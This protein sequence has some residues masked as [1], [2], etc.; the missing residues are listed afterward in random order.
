MDLGVML[1]QERIDTMVSVGAWPNKTILDYVDAALAQDPDLPAIT[2]YNGE[3]G[4]STSISYGQL[5][6][7]SRRMGLALIKSIDDAVGGVM[8]KLRAHELEENTM[9][10]FA[11]DNGAPSKMGR[12]EPGLPGGAPGTKGGVWNGSNNVPMRGEKGSL[13]EGGIR[14]P[15]FAYWKGKI[16]PGT[17]IEEM[18]TTLDLTATS[19]IAGGG[20]IPDEFDG[21]NLLPRLTGGVARI[22]RSEPMFWEFWQTQAV[23]IGDWKLWRSSKQELLFNLAKDRYELTNRVQ[24]DAKV[25]K[26]LRKKLDQWSATLPRLNQAERD[27]SEVFAWPLSGAPKGI[28]ADPRYLVPYADPKPAPYPA[29]IRR[30]PVN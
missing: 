18:V 23:R 16:I 21:V 11:S 9:I 7:L 12:D 4:H 13:F 19:L 24:S 26:R 5:D 1:T 30:V 15:M 29:P 27:A 10:L 20:T 6:R 25:A 2:D 17:V 3:T 14:V 8:A 22:E 28:G